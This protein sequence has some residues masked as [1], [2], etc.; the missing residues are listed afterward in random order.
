MSAAED[1]FADPTDRDLFNRLYTAVRQACPDTMAGIQSTMVVLKVNDR[2]YAYVWRPGPMRIPG[3]PA[4]YLAVSFGL[5]RQLEGP[6][7]TEVTQSY[8]GRW[9]YHVAVSKPADIDQELIGWLMAARDWKV[10]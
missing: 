2:P 3:R 8:S 6:R 1:F 5:N 9:M 4:H 10:R 7:L